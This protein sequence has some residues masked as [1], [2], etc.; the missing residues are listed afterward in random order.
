MEHYN[1]NLHASLLSEFMGCIDEIKLLEK[2][3]WAIYHKTDNLRLKSDILMRLADLN[4]K[5][6]SGYAILPD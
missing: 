3:Q 5:L 2:E 1:E 6:Q 4:M